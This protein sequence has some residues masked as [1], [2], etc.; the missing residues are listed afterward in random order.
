[1]TAILYPVAETAEAALHA[2]LGFAARGGDAEG[3]AGSGVTFATE[4]VGPAFPTRDAALAA[5]AGASS[6]GRRQAGARV[7]ARVDEAHGVR[8]VPV[9]ADAATPP[10]PVR[11]SYSAG[12]RWPAPATEPAALW[13]LSICFWRVGGEAAPEAPSG[14]ARRLRRDEAARD[15]TSPALNALARQPL[16]AFRPQQPLDIGLFE[17]RPP[18]APD[19]LIPDE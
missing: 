11:P 17:V 12:R 3:L 2:P 18:E 8:L 1:M 7:E 14:E 6:P 15:L 10:G 9:A 4:M 16:R 5:Y 13:R 19:T